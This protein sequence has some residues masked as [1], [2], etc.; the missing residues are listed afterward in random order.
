MEARTDLAC[1]RHL[2]QNNAE[3]E[4]VAREREE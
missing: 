3:G 4:T 2:F 1:D